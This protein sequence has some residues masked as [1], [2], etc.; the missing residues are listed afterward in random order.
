MHVHVMWKNAILTGTAPQKNAIRPTRDDCNEVP[1]IP[2]VWES[3]PRWEPRHMDTVSLGEKQEGGDANLPDLC[4]LPDASHQ[5]TSPLVKTELPDDDKDDENKG[6]RDTGD[7]TD[8]G[9]DLCSPAFSSAASSPSSFSSLT[10]ASKRR[11]KAV[12][13]ASAVWNSLSRLSTPRTPASSAM[14]SPSPSSSLSSSTSRRSCSAS[15]YAARSGGGQGGSGEGKTTGMNE[16]EEGEEEELE[17][18]A[19]QSPAP[20]GKM[21]GRGIREDTGVRTLR[22]VEEQEINP[23]EVESA[24][25]AVNVAAVYMGFQK[26]KEEGKE[27]RGEA[28]VVFPIEI[29]EGITSA[30][31]RL[32]DG[33][34]INEVTDFCLNVAALEPPRSRTY[35][36]AAFFSD[37]LEATPEEEGGGFKREGDIFRHCICRMEEVKNC[38]KN[39]REDGIAFREAVESVEKRALEYKEEIENREMHYAEQ[40]EA[41]AEEVEENTKLLHKERVVFRSMVEEDFQFDENLREK[42]GEV[43]DAGVDANVA[44]QASQSHLENLQELQALYGMVDARLEAYLSYVLDHVAALRKGM[45]PMLKERQTERVRKLYRVRRTLQNLFSAA[46]ESTN[47]LLQSIEA[48]KVALQDDLAKLQRKYT[49][50]GPTLQADMTTLREKVKEMTEQWQLHRQELEEMRS[51]HTEAKIDIALLLEDEA[52]EALELGVMELEEDKEKGE[53]ERKESDEAG[54]KGTKKSMWTFCVVM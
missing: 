41:K 29:A 49:N 6:K 23:S 39:E 44:L 2:Q 9:G 21:G 15:F 8:A 3:P 32:D 24:L 40:V 35:M 5:T 20:K 17:S 4:P 53:D 14:A 46:H 33:G 45:E 13:R 30:L 52:R 1:P 22:L 36:P 42:L 16:G 37:V 54:A 43:F 28:G 47:Y 31:Q 25:D 7:G 11:S 27:G 51:E 19:T 50:A 48:D 34:V 38:A 10:T 26:G 12:A 18:V